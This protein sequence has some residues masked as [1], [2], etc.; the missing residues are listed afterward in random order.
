VF[1]VL[2]LSIVSGVDSSLL[3]FR[4][5]AVDFF[6]SQRSRG[7]GLAEFTEAWA[8]HI[9][10]IDAFAVLVDAVTGSAAAQPAQ[11]RSLVFV[12]LLLQLVQVCARLIFSEADATQADRWVALFLHAPFVVPACVCSVLVA[13]LCRTL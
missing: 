2:G 9:M 10:Y 3:G 13:C 4:H 1:N 5:T 11:T 6:L 7:F 12:S 8:P